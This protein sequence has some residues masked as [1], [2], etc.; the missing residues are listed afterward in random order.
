MIDWGQAAESVFA[1]MRRQMQAA[2]A[3]AGDDPQRRRVAAVSVAIDNGQAVE[4]LQWP[5]PGS[6]TIVVA[7]RSEEMRYT[8]EQDGALEITHHP[9]GIVLGSITASGYVET[10]V[11]LDET[12]HLRH[13]LTMIAEAT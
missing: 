1:A 3:G 6:V 5:R 4:R 9:T 7:R 11:D 2:V 12:N 8:V 13:F 10:H